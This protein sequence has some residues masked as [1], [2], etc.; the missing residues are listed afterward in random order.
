LLLSGRTSLVRVS[1]TI[2]LRTYRLNP[3]KS[4]IDLRGDR[5]SMYLP[6]FFG[7]SRWDMTAPDVA[8]CDLQTLPRDGEDEDPGEFFFEGGVRL[9]YFFTTGPVTAPTLALLFRTPQRVPPLRFVASAASNVDLPFGYRSSRSKEGATVDG[10]LLRATDSAAALDRLRRAGAEVTTDPTLWLAEHRA[11]VTDPAQR[12]ALVAEDAR[13]ARL[14]TLSNGGFVGGLVALIAADKVAGV[15]A[16]SL[17]VLG[18][19]GLLVAAAT[20]LLG[21]LQ[22]R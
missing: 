15:L 13:Y 8:V 5:L 1:D 4:R 2:P 18:G 6:G 19:V 3:R 22:A 14:S 17:Y 9:P 16:T 7:K 20:R 10:A 21:R 12:E 11:L